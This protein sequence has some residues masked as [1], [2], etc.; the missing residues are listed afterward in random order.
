[1]ACLEGGL[2]YSVRG[3]SDFLAR[4]EIRDL[5]AYLRLLHNPQDVAALGRIINTPPRRLAALEKR[6]RSG[7]E[8]TLARLTDDFPCGLTANRG[9]QALADFLEVVRMLTAMA[10]GPPGLLIEAVLEMTGYRDW[11]RSQDDG[12]KR[13]TNLEAFHGLAERSDAEDLRE[14]LDE[15]SLAGELE[16]GSDPQGLALSTIHAAKGLEWPIV[17]VAGLEEGL[18]PHA[19]ALDGLE[20]DGRP[21]EEELRLCY[22]AATRAIDRLYLTY[23]ASRGT[24]GR[25]LP[26]APSRFLRSIPAELI[27]RRVA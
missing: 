12:E 21:L 1:M 18:L 3:N 7:D 2:A 17:F 19:R 20:V 14:F 9:V 24:Q 25:I 6:I 22:V 16:T 23:S 27:E 15:L 4:K 10:E 26:A 11:L 5:F 8:L 13:L